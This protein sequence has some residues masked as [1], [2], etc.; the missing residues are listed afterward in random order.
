MDKQFH[1]HFVN[2]NHIS[3]AAPGEDNYDKEL[4]TFRN[5]NPSIARK[6]IGNGP[7]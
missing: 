3:K 5:N 1:E 7:D 6:I 2:L 4:H